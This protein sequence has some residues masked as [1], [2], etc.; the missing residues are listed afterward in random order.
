MPAK[1]ARPTRSPCNSSNRFPMSS[2]ARAN[3]VGFTS[4]ANMLAER[5][6]AMRT[7][8]DWSKTVSSTFP[9]W[10]RAKATATSIRPAPNQ[11]PL[12]PRAVPGRSTT[13]R[14]PAHRLI[15][16]GKESGADRPNFPLKMVQATKGRIGTATRTHGYSQFTPN[17]WF[18][19]SSPTFQAAREP[20]RQ[21]T[22]T[23]LAPPKPRTTRPHE[24][25]ILH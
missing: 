11:V 17:K 18:M 9:N 5:S 13:A 12:G 8:R 24:S 25:G 1:Q 15:I 3:R 20:T 6:K 7:S 19:P 22:L 14:T 23:L 21:E 10:G 4:S 2:F 16:F